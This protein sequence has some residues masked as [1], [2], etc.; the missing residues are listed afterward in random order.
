MY[1]LCTASLLTGDGCCDFHKNQKRASRSTAFISFFIFFMHHF[2]CVSIFP[3]VLYS[4]LF[5]SHERR[6]LTCVTTIAHE[7]QSL[8]SREQ[9]VGVVCTLLV[10][11]GCVDLYASF[12]LTIHHVLSLPRISLDSLSVPLL[13]KKIADWL[14]LLDSHSANNAS[15]MF[16]GTFFELDCLYHQSCQS[17]LSLSLPLIQWALVYYPYSFL[18]SICLMFGPWPEAKNTGS[19]CF[20]QKRKEVNEVERKSQRNAFSLYSP[21][22]CLLCVHDAWTNQDSKNERRGKSFDWKFSKE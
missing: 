20:H 9:S 4:F 15:L 16:K 5:H 3:C 11:S 6:W 8:C 13:A 2:L 22:L 17:I 12:P 19:P 18:T 14:L 21:R 1:I 7:F 10:S